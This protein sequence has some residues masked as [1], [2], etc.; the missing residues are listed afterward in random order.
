MGKRGAKKP[1][2]FTCVCGVSVC[3]LVSLL[4][5]MWSS[6][7]LWHTL[8]VAIFGGGLLRAFVW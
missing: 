3:L 8:D 7:K 5:I 4:L 1:L 2:D 6:K